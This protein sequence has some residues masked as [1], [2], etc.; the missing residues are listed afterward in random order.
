V[1]KQKHNPILS[2]N[3]AP[4]EPHGFLPLCS[5]AAVEV[6]ST[7][8]FGLSDGT[9]KSDT[10]GASCA[11]PGMVKD[12]E[13]DGAPQLEGQA[14]TSR[15]SLGEVAHPSGEQRNGRDVVPKPDEEQDIEKEPEMKLRGGSGEEFCDGDKETVDRS[16]AGDVPDPRHHQRTVGA[17]PPI[18]LSPTDIAQ[19]DH[20][21]EQ[22]P[23][24]ALNRALEQMLREVA[25]V[26]NQALDMHV[27]SNAPPSTEPTLDNTAGRD[28][29]ETTSQQPTDRSDASESAHA[30]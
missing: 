10:G 6:N 18:A 30:A 8:Y 19:K 9:I 24:P 20:T 5:V 23:I 2:P 26:C 14:H 28:D 17:N 25:T 7:D 13:C 11:A 22:N 1:P 12:V 29:A 21:E 4:Y 16:P 3:P 27:A 15:H